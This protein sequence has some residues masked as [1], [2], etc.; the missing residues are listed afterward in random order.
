MPTTT[1]ARCTKIRGRASVGPAVDGEIPSGRRV[2]EGL[3]DE[4]V[5]PQQTDDGLGLRIDH[6]QELRQPRVRGPNLSRNVLGISQ[7]RHVAAQEIRRPTAV[8]AASS[9]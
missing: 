4:L 7:R 1:S 8:Q 3:V 2:D 5:A 6:V 9:P